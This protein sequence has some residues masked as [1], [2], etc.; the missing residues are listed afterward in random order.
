MTETAQGEYIN[1]HMIVQ[2]IGDRA[3]TFFATN[4]KLITGGREFEADTMA[5]VWSGGAN[6]EINPGN[7]I[8]AVVSFD[9]PPGTAPGVL[10]VH[11]SMF[12]GGAEIQ[13]GS[14]STAPASG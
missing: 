14:G 11:D 1:V 8:T 3:Q 4:Q 6:V 5:S 13:L 7:N 9:V 2:N 10:E 12:S